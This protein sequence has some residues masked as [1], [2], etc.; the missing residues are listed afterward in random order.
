MRR[1][2]GTC[3]A[4]MAAFAPLLALPAY[5]QTL[6]DLLAQLTVQW[7][8]PAEPFKIIGDV[9]YVGTKGL[10]SYLIV[11]ADKH[12]LIDTALPEAT[13]QI[14]SNIEKLGFKP[15]DI[16]LLLNTHA[17]FDHTGGLAQLKRET[18]ASLVAGE[19][20]KPLLET[21]LYPGQEGATELRFP[22]VMVDRAVRDGD[23]VALGPIRLTA[24]ATP[25]HSPGCTSWTMDV[26][27]RGERHQIVFFC[28]AT[29]ALNRLVGAP[30]HP[31][32]VEDYRHTFAE[33]SNIQ[34]DVFLAPHPEM[35]GLD[36]KRA[37]LAENGPNPFI[38][39]GEFQSYMQTMRTAFEEALAKQSAAPPK[40]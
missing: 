29:V 21:G 19:R 35:L 10:A 12:V 6:K 4:A 40:P 3:L 18:G 17:H 36:R 13:S 1:K 8:S 27:E 14:K 7:N 33:A 30:T 9:Y 26:T 23:V 22:P 28:S 34:A 20:D 5:A 32:I 38:K 16:G 39:P 15:S 2:L 31:G 25:G 11:G 37:A 24:H